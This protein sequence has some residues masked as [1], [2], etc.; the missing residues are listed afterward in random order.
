M[1]SL[2]GVNPFS[3]P[4]GQ[5]IER[6]TD[7]GLASEDWSLNLEI[8]D[9]IN[10]TDEGP[11]DA[12][13]AIRKRLTNNKNFKSVLLTLTVLES[14]IKNCGH[15]FHV[16]VAKKEFLDEMTKLLSP[17]LNPPQ[18][19]QEKILSLIQDWA[20]A[21][22]NSPD[23]SAILQTYEGLR[24]QGIEFP[25]KDLDTLS[26][27]F[28][29]HRTQPE[30]P[31]TAPGSV[32][33]SPPQQSPVHA[34]APVA[35]AQQP[36]ISMMGPVNPTPEQM[37]KL[38]SEL[39]IVQGN[40]QVMSEMLTEM[41]PGQEEPGDLDLL[42]E[43]NRTCRAMQQRIMELLEQVANEE[44]IGELL[45]INDDLNNVFIRY[46]RY[47][48][49][50]QAQ[51]TP[52]TPTEP[53]RPAE[54]PRPSPAATAHPVMPPRPQVPPPPA[55]EVAD[56][57][58]INFEE[59]PSA[60]AVAGNDGLPAQLHALTLNGVKIQTKSKAQ[61]LE[62]SVGKDDDFDMFAQSRQSTFEESRKGGASYSDNAQ[63]YD[64]AIT[65]SLSLEQAKPK[66]EEVKTS[67]PSAM[68]SVEAWLGDEDKEDGQ[69]SASQGTL[70]SQ[71]FDDFL[72]QRAA[73]GG[74]RS[75]SVKERG[76]SGRPPQRQMQ[77]EQTD[78]FFGL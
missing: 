23:M 54:P 76:G 4:V 28:T 15:R 31:A 77:M 70:S 9:I 68:E 1:A 56:D 59:E 32:S 22:R 71:D 38:K 2:F 45:R 62:E 21:F 29:P 42:Q 53:P 52:S 18:V 49:F 24:S 40:V 7:G 58:L 64:R 8:C 67:Q 61:T 19:V 74:Q 34:P 63:L 5:R 20:D 41:T 6:A 25:P 75:G 66:L 3:T 65:D 11:K 55:T 39:D 14:C 43:L 16:L 35:S 60:V 46:D 78:E 50:R 36:P 30:R 47:E 12:A 27:I 13:K 33:Q 73:S 51:S 69:V 44:V 26:P 48:R 57:S 72:A 37:A 17:K 10:E